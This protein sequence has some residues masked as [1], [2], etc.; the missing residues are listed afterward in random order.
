MQ[1]HQRTR[2]GTRTRGGKTLQKNKKTKYKQSLSGKFYVPTLL[3]THARATR[4]TSPS[5]PEDKGAV[6][7]RQQVFFWHPRTRRQPA[8]LR[9]LSDCLP[10]PRV[11]RPV[12][13]Q[14]TRR[15]RH[16]CEQKYGEGGPGGTN[17]QRNRSDDLLQHGRRRWR[18][19]HV[20]LEPGCS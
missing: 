18:L 1:M 3:H 2:A 11:I 16:D 20:D 6:V 17:R 10:H 12:L 15:E 19:L 9:S 5:Q 8:L 13:L 4:R 14:K 7:A